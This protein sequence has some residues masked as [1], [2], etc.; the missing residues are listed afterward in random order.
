MLF[1]GSLLM[2]TTFEGMSMADLKA[3]C[4]R[5]RAAL[6]EARRERDEA[7]RLYTAVSHQMVRVMTL[8]GKIYADALMEKPE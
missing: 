2:S 6:V 5:L 8:I 1:M 7:V 3:E 4:E